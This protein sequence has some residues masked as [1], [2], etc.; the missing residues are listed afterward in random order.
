M[1]RADVQTKLHNIRSFSTFQAI[2]AQNSANRVM[3]G[4]ISEVEG[5]ALVILKFKFFK[6]K[7]PQTA[8]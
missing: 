5:G 4:V 8:C 2:N 7:I 3:S 6:F 1:R